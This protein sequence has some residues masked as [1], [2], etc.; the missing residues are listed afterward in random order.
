MTRSDGKAHNGGRRVL[1]EPDVLS[2]IQRVLDTRG[3]N[4]TLRLFDPDEYTDISNLIATFSRD[5]LA[6]VGP[7]GGAMM[8]HRFAGPGTFVLE[9]IP[10]S[11][12][13]FENWEE[14]SLMDQTYA[15]MVV[16][17]EGGEH[18]MVIDPETVGRLLSEHLGKEREDKLEMTYGWVKE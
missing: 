1:N 3:R 8:N 16:E 13:L 17:S 10:T 15:T 12:F 6:I 4:E 18:D 5:A 7:H 14:A 9:F 2:A 11:W